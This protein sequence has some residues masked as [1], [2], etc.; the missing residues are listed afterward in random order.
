VLLPVLGETLPRSTDA[1]ARLLW[2][3][4]RLDFLPG[5]IGIE[6]G[7]CLGDVR[8][9]RPTVLFEDLA[10]VIDDQGHHPRVPVFVRVGDERVSGNHLVVDDVVDRASSRVGSMFCQD[11]V[12]IAMVGRV[13]ASDV[14]FLRGLREEFAG[15]R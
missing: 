2:R 13:L 15:S 3:F 11:L 12:V 10:R 4:G 5:R 1:L 9:V 8:C 14:A 6:R 7:H